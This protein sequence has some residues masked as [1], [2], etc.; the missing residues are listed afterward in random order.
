M[1]LT[2]LIRPND[3][4]ASPIIGEAAL[5]NAMFLPVYSTR[6]P[7]NCC[8]LG[9]IECAVTMNPKV[10][11]NDIMPKN[12]AFCNYPQD[13]EN[14][15]ILSVVSIRKIAPH[16]AEPQKS[17]KVIEAPNTSRNLPIHSG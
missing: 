12:R 3:G 10:T 16:K 15:P 7:T 14:Y 13:E 5:K 9:G 11:L 2:I 4:L 8:K 6:M 1:C 17:Y